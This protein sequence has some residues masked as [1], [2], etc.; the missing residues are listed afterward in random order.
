LD[1]HGEGKVRRFLTQEIHIPGWRALKALFE[2]VAAGF[3]NAALQLGI[4]VV[5]S[6]A[7]A[8][9]NVPFGPRGH[10]EGY[11]W[12]FLGVLFWPILWFVV[13]TGWILLARF[14]MEI[15]DWKVLAGLPMSVATCLTVILLVLG[16]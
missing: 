10:S 13:T 3:A 2:A 6:L 8:S 11:A 15:D 1:V 4:W 9:T 14:L 16:I 7:V 12:F 5:V